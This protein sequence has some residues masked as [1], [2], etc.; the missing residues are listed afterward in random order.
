MTQ[1]MRQDP[2]GA[3]R[4]AEPIP[5]A[6]G[7]D[8]EVHGTGRQRSAVAYWH[9]QELAHV[10]AGRFFRIRL[11]LAHRRLLKAHRQAGAG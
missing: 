8:W 11:V 7:I 6:D 5:Y 9:D 3:W 2:D 4:P 10:R 1:N